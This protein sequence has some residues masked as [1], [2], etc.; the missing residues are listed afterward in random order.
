MKS[1]LN[2]DQSLDCS[3]HD[4]IQSMV[5]NVVTKTKVH[6]A[7][8]LV[9]QID[10]TTDNLTGEYCNLFFCRMNPVCGQSSSESNYLYMKDKV[11]CSY[12]LNI[13]TC[14]DCSRYH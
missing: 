11:G 10:D 4:D 1:E 6:D 12:M 13:L 3:N 9:E 2:V 8:D 5:I 7:L 14:D